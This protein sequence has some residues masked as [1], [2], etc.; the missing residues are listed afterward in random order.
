MLS[1]NYILSYYNNFGPRI[2]GRQQ[3]STGIQGRRGS[4][5]TSNFFSRSSSFF[6]KFWHG[7]TLYLFLSQQD[8][9]LMSLFIQ[10]VCQILCKTKMFRFLRGVVLGLRWVCLSCPFSLSFLDYYYL[11]LFIYLFLAWCC[12][13][14]GWVCL[15]CPLIYIFLK[16]YYLLLSIY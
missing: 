4:P 1:Y 10:C 7:W 12:F 14:V 16:Y 11:L 15:S 9:F 2:V 5:G 13:E 8:P 3:L 6:G